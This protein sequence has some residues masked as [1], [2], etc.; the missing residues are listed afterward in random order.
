MITNPL[1]LEIPEEIDTPRLK[2]KPLEAD[3]AQFLWREIE[4]SRD[5]LERWMPWAQYH[6]GIADTKEFIERQRAHWYLRET[7][8]Y[9]IRH[10]INN[11]IMGFV[12]FQDIDWTI[13]SMQMGY[14]VGTKYRKMGYAIE[15][16]WAM[17]KVA[18]EK[19][20][21]ERLELRC[22]DDN[23]ASQRISDNAGFT[24]EGILKN[25]QRDHQ[26]QLVSIMIYTMLKQ[27]FETQ[28]QEKLIIK[29]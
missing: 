24:L 8:T 29:N 26:N 9:G 20:F 17:Q 13:P 5:S 12:S 16:V 21:I 28:K 19:L 14:W 7:F 4:D 3:D 11:N 27:E 6:I 1:L 10:K 22:E 18:F 25:S 2:L 15:A 23:M